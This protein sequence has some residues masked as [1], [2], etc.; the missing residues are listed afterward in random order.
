MSL[1]LLLMHKW[2]QMGFVYLLWLQTNFPDSQFCLI[3]LVPEPFQTLFQVL[4]T[5]TLTAPFSTKPLITYSHTGISPALCWSCSIDALKRET[6]RKKK[7][8]TVACWDC[9]EEGKTETW[10]ERIT[11]QTENDKKK[12]ERRKEYLWLLIHQVNT[13]SNITWT[14]RTEST[15]WDS[16]TC[17]KAPV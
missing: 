11:R 3:P 6:D 5:N 17:L 2:L 8:G 13:W 16:T 1:L 7:K 15:I 4:Y 9:T 12:D 10:R 14:T